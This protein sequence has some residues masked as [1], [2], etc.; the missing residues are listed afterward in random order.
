[1]ISNFNKLVFHFDN[2][3]NTPDSWECKDSK[4]IFPSAGH[5]VTGNLK[6]IPDSRSC[7]IVS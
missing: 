3:A 4:F 1:M 2:D 5:V 6:I 7:D